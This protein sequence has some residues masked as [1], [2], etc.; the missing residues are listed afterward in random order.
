MLMLSVLSFDVVQNLSLGSGVDLYTSIN[1][2]EFMGAC[3][4]GDLA[5]SS[6]QCLPPSYCLLPSAGNLSPGHMWEKNT[7]SGTGC[8]QDSSCSQTTGL[9][10]MCPQEALAKP[11]WHYFH[12][13]WWTTGV[14]GSSGFKLRKFAKAVITVEETP[15]VITDW[16]KQ[17]KCIF[18]QFSRPEVSG[19]YMVASS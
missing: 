18:P 2:I 7:V 4:L 19:V 16:V 13:S 1:G 14:Y 15:S 8:N 12:T 5:R 17:Q 3:F 9:S 11:Q 10:L 6:W